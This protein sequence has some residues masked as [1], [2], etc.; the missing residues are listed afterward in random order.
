M[1][2][3]VVLYRPLGELKRVRSHET[4]RA[5]VKSHRLTRGDSVGGQVTILGALAE[6]LI[7]SSL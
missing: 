6:A 5:T 2:E 7:Q 1:V 3:L 4:P